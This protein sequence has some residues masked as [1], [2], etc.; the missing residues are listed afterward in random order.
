MYTTFVQHKLKSLEHY[1]IWITLAAIYLTTKF[2]PFWA[3][4]TSILL[5]LIFIKKRGDRF[6]QFETSLEK[7]Q[8][9]YFQIRN[10]S[11]EKMK[12][13]FTLPA[14]IIAILWSIK[15]Y[16]SNA[17]LA[18][19]IVMPFMPVV[20][21]WFSKVLFPKFANGIILSDSYIQDG[22]EGAQYKWEE[23]RK[24]ILQNEKITLI[25]TSKQISKNMDTAVINQI[26]SILSENGIEIE[27][28]NVT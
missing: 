20:F 27:N 26:A 7:G 23:L 22:F 11:R 18:M 16:P 4:V 19:F 28:K 5:L 17:K 6:N 15:E 1:F 13:I 10:Y 9:K 24:A 2:D 25:L 21:I 12:D 3:I 8:L 14:L